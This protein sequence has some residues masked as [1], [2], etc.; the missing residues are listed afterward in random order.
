M[1]SVRECCRTRCVT[2]LSIILHIIWPR[3]VFCGA[4]RPAA[5][6]TV[7]DVYT[8]GHKNVAVHL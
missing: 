3:F 1:Q 2:G 7:A 8:L 4:M 6:I 5:T